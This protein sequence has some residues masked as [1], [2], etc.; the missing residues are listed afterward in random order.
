MSGLRDLIREVHRRSIW[1]ALGAYI[2]VGW[3]VF[4]LIQ[5]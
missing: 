2:A 3:L 1:W 4:E 5:Q